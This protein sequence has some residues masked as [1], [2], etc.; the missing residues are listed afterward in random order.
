ML[1][2]MV[3]ICRGVSHP[4]RAQ[5]GLFAGRAIMSGNKVGDDK[6]SPIK[7]VGHHSFFVLT[8]PGPSALGSL[9]S[10]PSDST[11]KF[12]MSTSKLTLLWLLFAALIKLVASTTIYWPPRWTFLNWSVSFSFYSQRTFTLNSVKTC[13]L[14]WLM[15]C[16]SSLKIRLRLRSNIFLTMYFMNYNYNVMLLTTIKPLLFFQMILW[17]FLFAAWHSR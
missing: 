2:V 3:Q 12:W 10:T 5:R 13:A 9:M 16:H 1:N 17:M 11:A 6:L 15:L 4:N 8:I 14:A 7:W